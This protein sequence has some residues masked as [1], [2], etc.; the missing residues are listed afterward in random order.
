[1][2]LNAGDVDTTNNQRKERFVTEA[3]T[4][5]A[6]RS[7]SLL[8]LGVSI[9]FVAYCSKKNLAPNLDS[10]LLAPVN[11]FESPRKLED[12]VGVSPWVVGGE[13]AP[14][15]EYPWFA[16]TW[17]PY[18]GQTFNFCGGSLVNPEFILTA[19]HCVVGQPLRGGWKVG[20]L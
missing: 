4:S 12:D 16:A 17:W 14:V 7:L 20:A 11:D 15:D 1:M 9:S 8:L 3:T 10:S 5:R 18:R 13:E 19:T 2:L 6:R